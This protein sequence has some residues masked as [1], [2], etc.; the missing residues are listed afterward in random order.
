MVS[1]VYLRLLIFLPAILIPACVSC[2]P[3]FCMIYSAYKLNKQ[4]DNI[5]P[6]RTTL[7][8]WNQSFVLCPALN[9]ASCPAYKFLRTGK[10]VWCSHLFKYIPQFVVIHTVKG[11]GVVNEAEV[12][13]FWNSITFSMIKN[14]WLRYNWGSKNRSRFFSMHQKFWLEKKWFWARC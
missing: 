12:D 3:A 11:L 2:S 7:P 5:Q 10:V 13:V 14:G 6:R 1:S 8:I 4:G 9:V